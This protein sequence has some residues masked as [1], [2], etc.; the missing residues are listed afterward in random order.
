MSAI[1]Q[2]IIVGLIVIAAAIYLVRKLTTKKD[3]CGGCCDGCK[4]KHEQ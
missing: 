3:P 2:G 1:V 4:N